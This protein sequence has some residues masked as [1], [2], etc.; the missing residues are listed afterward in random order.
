[1]L[2][3]GLIEEGFSVEVAGDGVAG[4]EKLLAD[5]VDVCILDLM[6]PRSSGLDLLERARNAGNKTPILILSAIDAVQD[7][8]KGLNLGADD[9]L[10][11]PFAFAEVLARTRALL[12][13]GSEQKRATLAYRDLLLDTAAHR[14]SRAG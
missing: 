10:A 8:V 7:R 1:M 9:Y 2:V 14:V 6:L 5:S 11:K 13:R 4:L 3:R 12:R